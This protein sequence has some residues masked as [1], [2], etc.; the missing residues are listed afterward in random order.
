MIGLWLQR[1]RYLRF[2]RHI[3]GAIRRRL[4]RVCGLFLLLFAA[5]VGA[6]MALEGLGAAD[7]VWLTITTATTVGYGDLS[8][9]T[10]L[11]RAATVLCM[12][13]FGIFLLAQGAS[14]LFD[15]RALQRE[16]RR[17]GEFKWRNM[18][19]HLLIVNVP[20]QDA[21]SYLLRLLHHVRRAPSL[22]DIPVQLLTP[23]YPDGLPHQL[24]EAGATHY[25]GVAEST[26][27]LIATNA[28][29]ARCIIVIAD[30][31]YDARSDAHTYDILSR[32]AALQGRDREQIVVAEAVEDGNRERIL[33]AGATTTLRPL[34]AYPEMVVRAL[35]APGVEQVI[36]NLFTHDADCLMRFDV[37]FQGLRWAN[38]VASFITGGGGLP[39]GYVRGGR[40]NTNPHPD[41]ECSGSGVIALIDERLTVTQAQV[42]SCLR[43]AAAIRGDA[44]AARSP[45]AS[46]RSP[47][48]DG[49]ASQSGARRL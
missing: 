21:D 30:E 14:E 17:R 49:S 32:L 15:Y 46:P 19:D 16:R 10:P 3:A 31:P 9:A 38:V 35:A 36:E 20:S 28:P 4:L 13:L 29:L 34:R 12:Y 26:D 6:M 43:A 11:G 40:V 41:D 23:R 48:D 25:N 42:E 37:A 7:A 24:V 2:T 8:A 45:L 18:K 5:H 22:A 44:C 27:N 1:R 39:L 33:A 47:I